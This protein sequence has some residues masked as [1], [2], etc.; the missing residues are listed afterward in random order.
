MIW[1]GCG[2]KCLPNHGTSQHLPGGI[3]ENHNKPLSG[4]SVSGKYL[5]SALSDINLQYYH[6]ANPL[7]SPTSEVRT[8]IMYIL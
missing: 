8:A 3:E 6:Y 1:G 4:E 5:N 2:R 7:S